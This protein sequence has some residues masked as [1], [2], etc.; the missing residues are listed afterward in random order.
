MLVT[1]SLVSFVGYSAFLYWYLQ[2]QQTKSLQL[3]KTVSKALSHNIAKLILLDDVSQASDITSQLSSF[4]DILSMILYKK[5]GTP[6]YKYKNKKFLNSID[7]IS[8]FK[9]E[10]KYQGMDLGYIKFKIKKESIPDIIKQDFHI[11]VFVYTIMILLTYILTM[12]FSKFFTDPILR[13]VKFL[14]EIDFLNSKSRIHTNDNSEF[15]LLYDEI[16]ALLD[17]VEETR[18]EQKLSSV[19]F[20]TPSCMLVTDKNERIL[21]ANKA[22]TKITG[23]TFEEVKGKTPEIL[24]PKEGDNKLYANIRESLRKYNYWSGEINTRHKDGKIYPKS[25]TIQSVFD[26]NNR[27]I[28][29]V[30]SFVDLSIE[31]EAQAK[32]KFLKQYDAITGFANR[33]LF[34]STF[35]NYLNKDKKFDKWGSL[36]CF[37]IKDFKA[38]NDTY[39]YSIGDK[40]LQQVSQRLKNDFSFSDMIGKIGA[41]QFV[42]WTGKVGSNKH[43]AQLQTQIYA[44][45]LSNIM[46]KPFI[47]DDKI[48]HISIYIGIVLYDKDANDAS[49]ILRQADTALSLSKSKDSK[50]AFFDKDIESEVSLRLDTYSELIIALQEKQFELY[51]QPQYDQSGTIKGVEELVRWNHPKKGMVFPSNFISIAEK[52]GLINDIGIY[53][54]KEACKQLAIWQKNPKTSHWSMAVNVSAKQF[55][56]DSFLPNLKDII[57]SSNINQSNLKIELTESILVEDMK[58]II[59]KMIDIKKLGIKISLDDFGTGYSSLQYLKYLPLDQIKIDQTFIVNM[60]ENRSDIA[61]IK[62]ILTLGETFGFEV[63]AEG[64]ESK[65]HYEKL[66][67]LGCKCFQGNYFSKPMSAKEIENLIR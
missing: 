61:I 16:N 46:K 57:E 33:E 66:K 49:L 34:V 47:I 58:N 13:L 17:K 45:F 23:Y 4:P 11:L 48:I 25:L 42:L 3:A 56:Q 15:A 63:M 38:I 60:F 9:V 40:L 64:V 18:S 5:D 62:T 30:L 43:E 26:D 28:Y 54:L 10:A 1:T 31:K 6:I 29:Y 24:L 53:V 19:A 35:Q 41:D 39:G 27:L 8:N 67:E 59:D 32:V 20:E 21:R 65:K 2:D 52:T 50:L 12:F 22:F 36:I 55:S 14:Y 44:H 7:S 37:N 51:Y